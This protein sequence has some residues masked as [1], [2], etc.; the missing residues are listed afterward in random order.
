M[1]GHR[2]PTAGRP[3]G[4]VPAAWTGALVGTVHECAVSAPRRGP[5]C[6]LPA[7]ECA[8]RPGGRSGGRCREV[9]RAICLGREEPGR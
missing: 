3:G 9:R 4:R 1:I 6:R 2:V 8:F 7:R 5:M